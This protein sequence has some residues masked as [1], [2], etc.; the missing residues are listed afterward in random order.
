MF[1]KYNLQ[2]SILVISSYPPKGTTYGDRVVGV[3]SFAKNSV[4]ALSKVTGKK[5]IVLAEVFN[6][7]EIYE[8]GNILVWR[9][10]HRNSFGLYLSIVKGL[11]RFSKV[12]QLETQFE[13]NSFGT[14]NT[15]LPY[16]PFLILLRIFGKSNYLTIH[17]VV[18]D[19]AT[20]SGHLG[21]KKNS[22]SLKIMNFF[23]KHY[24]YF[25]AF[26]CQKIVVMEEELKKR[27][28]LLGVKEGKIA[29]I[30]HGVDLNI[31]T[32]SQAKAKQKLGI[33]KNEKVVLL[34]GFLAWYK[35]SDLLIGAAK[36]SK[37]KIILAGGPNP[38]H[39]N[40]RFYTDYINKLYSQARQTK[41]VFI[42]DFVPEK[43]ISNYYC[44][45]DLVVLPYRSYMSSS[46]PLSLALSYGKPFIVSKV[47][48]DWCTN[49]R[50]F[51]PTELSLTK[52]INKTLSDKKLISKMAHESRE[53]AKTRDFSVLAKDYLKL[54]SDEKISWD[55]SDHLNLAGSLAS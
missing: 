25:L 20:L 35:G 23:L 34:F 53:L 38:N 36:N 49:G 9:C 8:E 51:V 47:L 16:P 7:E 15:M 14:I 45:A 41:N 26:G 46:G 17:Q 27:L 43:E 55:Y 2:D 39:L 18:I 52:A 33:R 24:Y 5:T 48:S 42:T 32:I 12:K 44:A 21:F 6:K 30:P 10:W 50:S 40:E 22:L 29:V 54:F 3:A 28:I 11:L 19:L 1:E 13:F 31:K 4:A 37:A